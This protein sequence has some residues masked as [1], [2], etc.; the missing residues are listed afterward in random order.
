VRGNLQRDLEHLR[1]LEGN[2]DFLYSETLEQATK[3][4]ALRTEKAA[5]DR[6]LAA[7]T[8]ALAAM[9]ARLGETSAQLLDARRDVDAFASTAAQ[10]APTAALL[11]STTAELQS[12]AVQLGAAREEVC[13]LQ[14]RLPAAAADQT[15]FIAQLGEKGGRLVLVAN[16][17]RPQ[18]L[19]VCELSSYRAAR[20]ERADA[21]NQS[22]Y[23][24]GLCEE[25][26]KTLPGKLDVAAADAWLAVRA[27]F[28]R[29]LVAWTA[30]RT[31]DF[32]RMIKSAGARA[33]AAYRKSVEERSENSAHLLV[34]GTDLSKE[35]YT[36]VCKVLTLESADER[37]A[38]EKTLL[39]IAATDT[40]STRKSLNHRRPP[41]K[42]VVSPFWQDKIVA[43]VED[44]QG[45]PLNDVDVSMGGGQSIF[46]KAMP[47]LQAFG[48]T[49]SDVDKASHGAFPTWKSF[50]T[51]LKTIYCKKKGL[52]LGEGKAHVATAKVNF[53]FQMTIPG[54]PEAPPVTVV[55]RSPVPLMASVAKVDAAAKALTI[56]DRDVSNVRPSL[57]YR[58][59]RKLQQVPPR[60]AAHRDAML[61]AA[62]LQTGADVGDTTDFDKVDWNVLDTTEL[63]TGG[64][65]LKD[66]RIFSDVGLLA[67]LARACCEETDQAAE[68]DEFLTGVG[69]NGE[70]RRADG[71]CSLRVAASP[72]A[73]QPMVRKETHE[74]T[75]ERCC[76]TR[77]CVTAHPRFSRGESHA[78]A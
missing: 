20:A 13:A 68:R 16:G 49:M 19:F 4:V 41:P 5:L 66:E 14:R 47:I 38:R 59:L 64:P 33:V 26:L 8:A 62:R 42:A 63:A 25:A 29:N 76:S 48:A 74:G 9:A 78:L 72:C 40:A 56:G 44:I 3:L 32:A 17:E 43:V 10:L 55:L 18:E 73:A 24:R 77:V 51:Y 52:V 58:D 46:G 11:A 65:V 67:H 54:D 6:E 69:E 30:T 22:R 12:T 53:E 39:E 27:V 1:S 7:T 15:A 2:A 50:G 36:T 28:Q 21:Y 31:D 70:H 75:L 23:L 61:L 35:A 71:N 34:L 60:L 57:L 45:R 37:R